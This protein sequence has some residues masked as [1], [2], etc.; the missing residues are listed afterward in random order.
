[1]TRIALSR[2]V[3]AA[4]MVF[5]GL[6]AG[7]TMTAQAASTYEY[8][9]TLPTFTFTPGITENDQSTFQVEFSWLGPL[10]FNAPSG[11]DCPEGCPI[12]TPG[13]PAPGYSYSGIGFTA[14]ATNALC[15]GSP[16]QGCSEVDINFTQSPVQSQPL[17]NSFTPPSISFALIEP[18]SF[19]AASGVHP[20]DTGNGL[21]FGANWAFTSN[22][23]NVDPG[24]TGC[25]ISTNVIEAA[26]EPAS[27]VLF[28]T[29]MAGLMLALRRYR[30]ARVQ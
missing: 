15:S 18:D 10:E 7:G 11:S 6:S 21:D 8:T 24:C 20:F 22:V 5:I 13:S 1:L 12:G 30:T 2:R 17:V 14:S 4:L 3:S 26:P 29:A 27:P 9:L 25:S 19:W 16:S 23:T 28:V